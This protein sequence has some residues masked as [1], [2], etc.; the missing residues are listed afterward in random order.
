LTGRDNDLE[1]FPS[2]KNA[3][4]VASSS[5]KEWENLGGRADQRGIIGSGS[6]ELAF[7]LHPA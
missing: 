6:P 3:S 4:I 1:G 5:R 7:N 2:A